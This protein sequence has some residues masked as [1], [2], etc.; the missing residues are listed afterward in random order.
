MSRRSGVV[1]AIGNFDGLHRGHRALLAAARGLADQKIADV[2]V[3]TF[4][5]HPVKVLASQM[6]PP[7]IL[8][9]DEKLAGLKALGV[10]VVHV[11][12]FD[13]HLA[14]MS[15]ERFIHEVLVQRLDVKGVVVGEGFRFGHRA[16]GSIADLRAVFGDDAVAVPVVKEGGLVCSSTKVRE[17]VLSGNVEAAG[18]LLGQPYFLEGVVVRG[19]GRGRTIGIPTANVESGRELLPKVGVY[20]T[21]AVLDD[22]RVRGSVTNV[23]LRP[24]FSGEGVRVEAHVFDLDEDLY[25][26]RVRLDMVARIRDERRFGGVQELIAQIKDDS[27][28]ARRLLAGTLSASP[29]SSSGGASS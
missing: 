28:T 20:A 9:R 27:A 26:R 15:P 13:L 22:G 5:P 12:P 4:D 16:A 8:R 25:G 14:A 6:A 10:D 24:T 19:D 18:V 23:G 7:L 21:R 17:L 1:V 29:P 3:V 11:V 2:G